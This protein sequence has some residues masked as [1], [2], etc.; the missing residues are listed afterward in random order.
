MGVPGMAALWEDLTA[1]ADQGKLSRSDKALFKKLVKVLA[2]LRDN[3]RHPSLC[4]HDIEALSK[5]YGIITPYTSFLIVEDEPVAPITADEDFK[6]D[7]GAGAGAASEAVRGFA[8][9]DDT[10]QAGSQG[11]G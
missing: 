8:A 2:Y 6:A 9:A 11:G 7:S 1:R 3:P 4:S 5:R 10:A